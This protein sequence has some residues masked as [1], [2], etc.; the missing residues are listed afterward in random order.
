MKEPWRLIFVTF[1]ARVMSPSSLQ[2]EFGALIN[3]STTNKD[4]AGLLQLSLTDCASHDGV[5][6]S[7]YTRHD[8]AL[9]SFEIEELIVFQ[10]SM[11]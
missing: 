7:V 6:N 8:A 5:L 1:K 4:A 9:D 11:G 2:E 10:V 3:L